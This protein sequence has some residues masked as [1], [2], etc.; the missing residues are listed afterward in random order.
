M[1]VATGP[2]IDPAQFPPHAGWS[3]T[4]MSIVCMRIYAY[5][6]WPLYKVA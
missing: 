2:R 3:C 5:A 6:T 1:V 4:I